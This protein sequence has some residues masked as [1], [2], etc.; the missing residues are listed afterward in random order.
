MRVLMF[1][2]LHE[3]LIISLIS[4]AV[5]H[6]TLKPSLCIAFY[7]TLPTVLASLLPTGELKVA[8][9]VGE[10]VFLCV[11]V[12]ISVRVCRWES[13]FHGAFVQYSLIQAHLCV[14]ACASVNVCDRCR[15]LCQGWGH[16]LPP[17]PRCLQ[18]FVSTPQVMNTSYPSTHTPAPTG[19]HTPSP[20]NIISFYANSRALDN[21][22]KWGGSW[23]TAEDMLLAM[24]TDVCVV[25]LLLGYQ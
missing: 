7:L 6:L 9:S 1:Y 13:V 22:G 19:A 25:H 8:D 24:H 3:T 4:S 15:L 2:L 20:L 5:T 23:V 18:S 12:C 17:Q 21:L 11:C 10:D 14:F 16:T